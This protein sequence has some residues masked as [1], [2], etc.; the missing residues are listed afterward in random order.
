M[1]KVRGVLA[2]VVLGLF[3]I[4]VLGAVAG[5]VVAVAA[6]FSL[7]GFD[8]LKN[9]GLGALPVGVVTGWR[10]FRS[11]R[12]T[13]PTPWRGP[14]LSRA[15][16]P[17]L[18]AEIDAV[19]EAVGTEGPA[20]LVVDDAVNAG[21][22]QLCDQRELLLGLPLLVGL[23]V[24][25]LRAVLAHELG[26]YGA[27]H[28]AAAL[29]AYRASELVLTTVES[30]SGLLR[31]VL[32]LYARLYMAVAAASNRDC[33]LE[34][35]AFAARVSGPADAAAALRRTLQLDVAWQVLVE[36]YLPLAG[37]ARRRPRVT[38]GLRALL[39][40]RQNDLRQLVDDEVAAP[41]PPY[42]SDTHPPLGRR[43]AGF[44]AQ[45]ASGAAT[46]SRRAEDDVPVWTLLTGGEATLERLEVELLQDVDPVAEWDDIVALAGGRLT[47]DAAGTL[48]RIA[49]QSG[50]AVPATLDNLLSALE[51]GRA[52]ALGA[53]LV[54]PGT[55]PPERPQA[56]RRLLTEA[57]GATVVHALV[58]LG[59]A[60]HALD[61]CDPRR[62]VV[63]GPD[64]AA[65]LDVDALV[66]PA[67]ADPA[68][69]SALRAA[70]ARLGV[71]SSARP[72][73]AP[74]LD[75]VPVG[76]FL[77][78]RGPDKRAADLLVCDTGLLVV[79][80]E[81]EKGPWAGLRQ[82]GASTEARRQRILAFLDASLTELL[83]RP[84]ARWVDTEDILAGR[85]ARRPWGWRLELVLTTGEELS[86]RSTFDTECRGDG[87]GAVT[88]LIGARGLPARLSVAARRVRARPVRAPAENAEGCAR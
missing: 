88:E 19:A 38:E 77:Q 78:V 4:V 58:E 27:G 49:E 71:P 7:S 5:V 14:E 86:I 73:S 69:V 66:G 13:R 40:A 42:W 6:V 20:R 65:D 59:R 56:E 80:A 10:A 46:T 72:P 54:K 48:A 47:A 11:V 62:V 26:H 63:D 70:L 22:R 85:L 76:V 67:V 44:E 17:A 52:G 61:W 25:Q 33:E 87:Y 12:R 41:A 84:G 2:L 30:S 51:R 36:D 68:E 64:G 16:H 39:S 9:L 3:P 32:G 74:A 55:H 53:G 37:P 83:E 50:E 57:L 1:A 43:I 28:T 75:P 21:V 35:D 23:T 15:E 34:A 29:R 8:V 81:R 79:P 24:P 82:A 18:W 31:R 45:L 60:R